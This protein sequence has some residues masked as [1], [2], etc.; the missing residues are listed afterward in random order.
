MNLVIRPVVEADGTT[1]H[2]LLTSPHVVRGSMRVPL[3]PPQQTLDRIKPRSGLYQLAADAGDGLVGFAELVTY[4]DE[5]RARHCGEINMVAT[6]ADW[7]RQGIG[8]RLMEEL[9]ELADNWLNL[10]RLGMIVFTDNEH[11]IRLY[12][13]LG[14][15]IEGT[16]PRMGFG[17][18]RWMDAHL[19][20]R[21][22]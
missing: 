16:M 6:H 12:E 9:I 1:L 14:F 5:P 10:E 2:A 11:A 3:S 20:G 22:R 18:G 17:A 13:D 19:M 21:L 7:V 8:R 4:P 15:A